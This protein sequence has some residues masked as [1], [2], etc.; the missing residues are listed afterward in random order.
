MLS[1]PATSTRDVKEQMLRDTSWTPLRTLRGIFLLSQVGRNRGSSE[2]A[3]ASQRPADVSNPDRFQI[4][5]VPGAIGSGACP[6]RP[7]GHQRRWLACGRQVERFPLPR[8]RAP[9]YLLRM[10]RLRVPRRAAPGI[11]EIHEHRR[12]AIAYRSADERAIR[13]YGENRLGL[14]RSPLCA[15]RN[16]VRSP[17]EDRIPLESESRKRAPR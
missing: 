3:K 13:G 12:N 4:P 7:T 16:T 9:L 15:P 14:L 10:L 2:T 6:S 5:A 1:P 11:S 8:L 17:C